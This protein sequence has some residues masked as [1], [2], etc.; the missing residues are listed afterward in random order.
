MTPT[1]ILVT[2]E[3]C[4]EIGGL[5]DNTYSFGYVDVVPDELTAQTIEDIQNKYPDCLASGTTSVDI[6]DAM[7][8]MLNI[9]Y[10]IFAVVFLMVCFIVVSMSRHIVNE[11]MSVIGM[12]RSIGG[13]V[14]GTGM[15]LM[16]ES[17]FYGLCG[18]VLGCLVYLPLKNRSKSFLLPPALP[19]CKQLSMCG[20]LPNVPEDVTFL[21]VQGTD[22]ARRKP[23]SGRYR[24]L[25]ESRFRTRPGCPDNRFRKAPH[26]DKRFWFL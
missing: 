5:D 3:L 4:R 25:P 22:S 9:Y 8:G 14:A 24:L 21:P 13:S 12:L 20:R 26:P 23:H 7:G 11:R 10:L 6:E 17:A 16:A 15:I 18:G 1:A 2:P 19:R